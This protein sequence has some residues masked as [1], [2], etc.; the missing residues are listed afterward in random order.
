MQRQH[1]LKRREIAV[2][3]VNRERPTTRHCADQ[4]VCI[5]SL[6]TEGPALVEVVSREL[7]VACLVHNVR[8]C[9]EVT[10]QALEL[11]WIPDARKQFLP[12]GAEHLDP[13]F[14]HEF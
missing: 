12:N 3:R 4:K 1:A 7:E 2:C 6:H 10:F 14:A 11:G 9:A 13:S 8:K 5:R